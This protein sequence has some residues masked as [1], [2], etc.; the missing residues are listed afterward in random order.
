MPSTPRTSAPG[1]AWII[2]GPTSGMG[3][4]AALELAQHGT[5]VLVGRDPDKLKEVEQEVSA[6]P[7]GQAVSVLCD[8]SDLRSVRRAAAE[9]VALDLP[10][11]GLA[12]NAGIMSLKDGDRSAQGWDLSFATNHLGPFVLTEEL[13]PHLPD[14]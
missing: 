6:L 1:K 13:I 4:V 11:A 3:H 12:N 10:L 5:V 8:F 7:G 2:T 14:G 9:I